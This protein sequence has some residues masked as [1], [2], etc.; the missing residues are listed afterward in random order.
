M[1]A[2][3]SAIY[4]S[5]A[6]TVLPHAVNEA[7][8]HA[9][10]GLV[11]DRYF[12]GCGTF[13]GWEPKG[14]G[15]ELTLI[16]GEVLAELRLSAAEA[17]RNLVTEGVRLNDLV[18]KRF[19]IGDVLIKG[20]RLCPPCTHLDKVTGQALLKPLADRGGLRADILSD[21]VIRVGDAITPEPETLMNESIL[22]LEADLSR[23]DHAADTLRLLD[24][25]SADPMGDG[26]PLADAAR[27]DLIPGLRQHPTTHVFL[28]YADGVAVG[29]AICFL[30]FSTFAARRLLYIMDYFVQP[31]HRGHGIGKRLMDALAARA[32]EL[33]CCRLT[34]EVQEN[35][36]HARRIYAAAGFE[37]A[38]YVPEAGGA[39][40]MHKSL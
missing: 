20:I 24:A 7:Q 1:P 12:E 16:E 35:N 15:R 9:H 11:G 39:L 8:A 25:Y 26:H 13:T 40:C 32:R 10:R 30:G 27:R 34:L 23:E 33:G 28:A 29:I 4:I 21:G 18:G 6:A 19:R 38:V 2:R 17:R 14:P 36:H 3:V 31:T 5:P 22:T 37:Q